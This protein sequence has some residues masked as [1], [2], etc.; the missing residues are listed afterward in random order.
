[1]TTSEIDHFFVKS[2][3]FNWIDLT[4]GEI[5]L[6]DDLTEIMKSILLNCK[7]LFLLHF[8]TNGILTD[9]IVETVKGII[10]FLNHRKVIITVSLDGDEELHNKIRGIPEGYKKSI[11]TFKQLRR[12]RGIEVYL[13]TTLSSYNYLQLDRI[14][15][16]VKKEYPSLNP[17]DFHIN[18]VHE[19]NFQYENESLIKPYNAQLLIQ[20]IERFISSRGFSL[21]PV[22][23]LE[24]YYLKLIKQY[25]IQK[26]TPLS[27]KAFSSSCYISPKGDVYPCSLY[28]RKIGNIK[29]ADYDLRSIWNSRLN[30]GVLS[31][32]RKKNCPNCWTPC[33]AYQNILGNLIHPSLFIFNLR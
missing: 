7:N 24:Y 2:N 29:E 14:F 5:F 16:S 22:S 21:N 8:P 4:G 32:I 28:D 9:R 27:C 19:S 3:A 30:N 23:V 1:M 20:Q 31:E 10:P 25:L 6:R 17:T 18:I 33:E 11:E 12:I 26:K 13:G 15:E